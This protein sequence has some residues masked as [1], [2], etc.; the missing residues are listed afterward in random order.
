MKL[1]WFWCDFA[2]RMVTPEEATP[3]EVLLQAV[4][5]AEIAPGIGEAFERYFE[6]VNWLNIAE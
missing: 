5:S 2:G 6:Q 3:E 4:L 1:L